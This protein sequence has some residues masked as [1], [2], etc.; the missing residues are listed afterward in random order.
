MLKN[1]VYIMNILH[2]SL[3][4]PPYRRGGMTKYCMDLIDE[5]KKAGHKVSLL[6]PGKYKDSSPKCHIKKHRANKGIT[7]YEI[8]NT[9]PVPL[10]DGILYPELFTCKKDKAVF[11]EFL[12]KENFDVLHIHTLMGL[13]K[14]L[15]ETAY[16]MG[17]KTVFTSHDYF[18]ICPKCSLLRGGQVCVDD[19]HCAD[20]VNCCKTG[21]S[22]KKIKIIQSTPYK[23]AKNFPLIK[24]LRKNHIQKV[25]QGYIGNSQDINP[26]LIS[27]DERQKYIELR[28]YYMSILEMFSSVH[29]N[30]S[31]T[32][33]IYGKYGDFADSAEVISISNFNI[34]DNRN[35]KKVSD[36]LR[37]AYLGPVGVRK[38]YFFLNDVLKEIYDD[39]LTNFEF[40]IYNQLAE[41]EPY[42]VCH[43]PYN[44]HTLPNVMNNTDLLI[45][46]SI[47]Y[48]TFGFTVLEAL[49]YGVPVLVSENVGAKDLIIPGKNG[50]IFS[51]DKQAIKEKIVH[52]LEKPQDVEQMN[53]YIYEEQ[54]IK[55][56]KSHSEEILKL[57]QKKGMR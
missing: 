18:G 44:S 47:W 41:H 25:N 6:W 39:G 29:F 21:M 28:K 36:K 9:H 33:E 31:L 3:G 51:L 1:E 48:E 5:Q 53:R 55:T 16:D 30:S 15:I 56:M 54:K 57:Y 2:Y 46:P 40:H 32:K 12:S 20:C 24:K 50:E 43:D 17:I 8:N 10:L 26:N 11:E 7:N 45:V 49:S 37:I 13:P 19:H 42:V 23:L 22:I 14:E 35:I 34:S 38:G 4:F 27:K 52:Y